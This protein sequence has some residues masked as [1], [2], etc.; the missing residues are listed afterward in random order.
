MGKD[1]Y[2]SVI[3]EFQCECGNKKICRL[4]RF[5]TGHTKSCGC[6]TNIPIGEAFIFKGG[7]A[8]STWRRSYADGCSFEK[9]L[10]LSQQNCFYCN[11]KPS[12]HCKNF[13]Y[14]GLDRLNS[15]KDHSEDNIVPCCWSCN[16]MKSNMNYEE[17]IDKITKIYF[18]LNKSI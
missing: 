2:G 8:K 6:L 16:R 5:R 9:F 4:T 7:P 3:W 13:I 11:A 1:K 14:N 17:F 10:E 15:N 12:T 18:N